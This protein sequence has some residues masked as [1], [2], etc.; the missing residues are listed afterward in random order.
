V[1]VV[2]RALVVVSDTARL[3]NRKIGGKGRML[4]VERVPALTNHRAGGRLSVRRAHSRFR[5]FP[6]CFAEVAPAAGLTKCSGEKS[7]GTARRVDEC[8]FGQ[9]ADDFAKLRASSLTS[10]AQF[11][12]HVMFSVQ[13]PQANAKLDAC[14]RSASAARGSTI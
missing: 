5:F 4:G 12:I 3:D 8:D 7:T 1:S 9:L 14:S 13:W 11:H 10:G 2:G 6:T